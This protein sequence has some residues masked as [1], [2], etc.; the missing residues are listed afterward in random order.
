MDTG[1]QTTRSPRTRQ[2]HER[3]N[4]HRSGERAN[5]CHKVDGA[6]E[7]QGGSKQTYYAACI[8]IN[9]FDLT[10]DQARP[11][12]QEW[13]AKCQP[14]WSERELDHK[15]EDASQGDHN[16][17]NGH[18]L[19]NKG[20]KPKRA[21]VQPVKALAEPTAQE[22][23]VGGNGDISPIHEAKGQQDN[24]DEVVANP[25]GDGF[26]YED[27]RV[28]V[29]VT[30]D[31]PVI[32]LEV[33]SAVSSDPRIFQRGEILVEDIRNLSDKQGKT[34]NEIGSFKI[35]PISIAKLRHIIGQNVRFF[36][37]VPIKDE[38]GDIDYKKVYAHT[39]DWCVNSIHGWGGYP[40]FKH[41]EGITEVPILHANGSIF[42]TPGYDSET[43]MILRAVWR[44]SQDCR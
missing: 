33:L 4:H 35:V 20:K 13:N 6:V 24:T 9:G 23:E 36:K 31:E 28:E 43:R 39:P 25:P 32:N 26:E 44:V 12:L 16:K 17:P 18:L 38:D 37:M 21:A 27:D 29:E 40:G 14:E 5:T 41:L 2:N 42:D 3:T 10:V 7:G 8:L 19:E 1:N 34:T 15:L 11:L 30:P 22:K